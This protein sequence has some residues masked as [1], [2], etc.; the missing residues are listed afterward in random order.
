MV[1]TSFEKYSDN[2][3]AKDLMIVRNKISF[4]YDPK[5]ISKGY[6]FFY[7]NIKKMV[8]AYISRGRNMSE[9]RFYF[10]DAAA[11]SYMQFLYDTNDMQ[12]FLNQLVKTYKN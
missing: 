8:N 7:K 10:A 3:L 9:S 11:E 12:P 1:D 4:H 6:D 2:K 5:A